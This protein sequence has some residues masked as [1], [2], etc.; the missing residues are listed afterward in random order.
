MTITLDAFRSFVAALDGA[1]L[2]TIGDGKSFVVFPA[3][4]CAKFVLE[5]K[6]E[7]ALSPV[8][9]QKCAAIFAVT[10]SL[11]TS[12]YHDVTG[13][14]SYVLG[15]FQ[16]MQQGFLS[17]T[18]VIILK[19]RR[20][21]TADIL[22]LDWF[23][24]DLPLR[25]ATH[26]M[27]GP[28]GTKSGDAKCDVTKNGLVVTLDYRP[29]SYRYFNIGNGVDSGVA[30][31]TFADADRTSLVKLEWQAEGE[32]FFS[33]GSDFDVIY[34]LP[35]APPYTPPARPASKVEQLVRL[36]PGQSLFKMALGLA[37]EGKC[38]VTGCDVREVLEA[39]HIDG[40]LAPESNNVSNGL[41]LRS[42][43]HALFDSNLLGIDPKTYRISIHTSAKGQS[44]YAMWHGR[45]IYLPKESTHR[46]NLSALTRRWSNFRSRHTGHP[47]RED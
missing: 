35:P 16:A 27:R 6:M 28:R 4:D 37:Y 39:A 44:G 38:C 1:P 47:T 22:P 5:N 45:E 13:L 46:P 10:G 19:W 20:I 3:N 14:S 18:P 31:L 25:G 15:V 21:R 40:Y 23:K 17:T 30:R 32:T 36:R 33:D 24:D 2:R 9:F 29:A 7:K 41:L 26:P 12:D 8:T 34:E 42:D 43:V 11:V